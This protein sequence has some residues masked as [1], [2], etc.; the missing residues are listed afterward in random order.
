MRTERIAKRIWTWLERH[1]LTYDARLYPKKQW[2]A[3][4][5]TFGTDALFTI[6]TEGPLY[7][8]INY[9]ET[10]S[11]AR[12]LAAFTEYVEA[13][14]VWYELGYAWSLHFYPQ[15]PTRQLRRVNYTLNGCR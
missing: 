14:G 3:R 10:P 1:D 12:L 8:L 2:R 13:Q 7:E 6:V 11:A 5:E 9:A 15:E 4:G